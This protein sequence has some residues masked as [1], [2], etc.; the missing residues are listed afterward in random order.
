[1]IS[2]FKEFVKHNIEHDGVYLLESGGAGSEEQQVEKQA[3]R[4]A[5]NIRFRRKVAH[6]VEEII[7]GDYE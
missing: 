6:R 3:E 7:K 2:D 5:R 1:M 4:V